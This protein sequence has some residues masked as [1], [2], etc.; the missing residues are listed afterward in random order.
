MAPRERFA[1]ICFRKERP[2][3]FNTFLAREPV[4]YERGCEPR[5]LTNAIMGCPTKSRGNNVSQRNGESLGTT[6]V[7]TSRHEKNE[8]DYIHRETRGDVFTT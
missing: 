7:D 8:I 2:G 4:D 1:C 6:L 3:V 5:G